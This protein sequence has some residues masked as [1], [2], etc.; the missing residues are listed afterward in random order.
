MNVPASTTISSQSRSYS[1]C[2]PSHQYDR[3]RLAEGGHVVDPV[4]ECVVAE[5]GGGSVHQG[6]HIDT[7]GAHTPRS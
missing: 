2:E 4:A 6:V 1:A 7:Q 5:V 3:I